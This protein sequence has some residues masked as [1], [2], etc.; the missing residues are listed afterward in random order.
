MCVATLNPSFRVYCRGNTVAL[1]R[2]R[3]RR[4]LT[5]AATRTSLASLLRYVHRASP[6]GY[7]AYRAWRGFIA[8][9]GL[10]F[11]DR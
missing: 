10:C 6:A 11:L 3:G 4:V 9:S 1:Y 5:V 8:R 7:G 2:V